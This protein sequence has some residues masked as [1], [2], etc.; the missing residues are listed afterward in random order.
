MSSMKQS[1]EGLASKAGI[2]LTFLTGDRS[3]SLTSLT[4]SFLGRESRK[5]SREIL[6]SFTSPELLISA[7]ATAGGKVLIRL[8]E[9]IISVKNTIYKKESEISHFL[10]TSTVSPKEHYKM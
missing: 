10:S 7:K 5:S 1:A 9:N 3:N 6:F 4:G 8:K 2:L